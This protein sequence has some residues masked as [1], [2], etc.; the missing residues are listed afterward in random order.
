MNR[1]E[2]YDLLLS[3]LEQEPIPAAL[4]HCVEQARRRAKRH[5]RRKSWGASLASLGGA[6]AAFALAVN[7]SIPFAMACGRVPGLKE[8]AAA[9]ALSPSLK[10]A[11]QN[12]FVQLVGQSQTVEGVTLTVDYII[13]D[14]RQVNVFYHLDGDFTS[15][16]TTPHFKGVD[17]KLEGFSSSSGSPKSAPGEAQTATADFKERDTPTSLRFLL[18]VEKVV[19]QPGK[20]TPAPQDSSDEPP[21]H[22]APA[23]FTFSMDLALD[24]AMISQGQV[25][26]LNQWVDLDGQ[27]ILL[28]TVEIYP[29]FLEITLEDDP[30]NTAWLKDLDFY[31]EDEKGSRTESITNGISGWGRADSPAMSALRCES[32]FFWNARHLTLHIT[33]ADWLDKDRRFATVDLVNGT[34][35]GILPDGVLFGGAVKTASGGAQ[36][37]FFG[38]DPAGCDETHH[39]SYQIVGSTAR[40]LEE[41]EVFSSGRSTTTGF[42]ATLGDQEIE[43][44]AE[45]FVEITRLP[46]CPYDTV[47]VEFI[48]S[49][50]DVPLSREVTAD[51][52]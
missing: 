52:K 1:Q 20:Q 51:I 39:I 29:S 45:H 26:D 47:E 46:D 24:P 7:L 48:A 5:S 23:L 49:R 34:V 12:D 30:A 27:N 11:V 36:I 18:D 4:D 6:A 14:K 21:E 17:E 32:S 50:R 15:I 43:V 10:A 33:A 28:K 2:E 9:V 8:L 13:A 42:Y 3:Q 38:Q 44:P 31:L 25:Y 35:D 22:S 37:A 41:Q 16:Y 19:L 40:G